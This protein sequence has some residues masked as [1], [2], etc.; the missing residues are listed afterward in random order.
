MSDERPEARS[1]FETGLA[2]EYF[3]VSGLRAGE[4]SS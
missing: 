1:G 4:A 2:T 3:A